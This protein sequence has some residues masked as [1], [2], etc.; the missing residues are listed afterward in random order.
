MA[1]TAFT[2]HAEQD[3][4]LTTEMVTALM[5]CWCVKD[6]REFALSFA[7]VE[8]SYRRVM[9]AAGFPVPVPA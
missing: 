8:A 7:Q 3:D 9:A 1:K 2:S 4:G 6:G 5:N